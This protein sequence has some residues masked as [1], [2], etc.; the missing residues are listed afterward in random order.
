MR[1]SIPAAPS[2]F[3][4]RGR[5]HAVTDAGSSAAAAS[6]WSFEVDDGVSA[7]RVRHRAVRPRRAGRRGCLAADLLLLAPAGRLIGQAPAPRRRSTKARRRVRTSS[8]SKQATSRR[9]SSRSAAS[10]SAS[11]PRA[12]SALMWARPSAGCAASS[13]ARVVAASPSASGGDDPRH[14][15]DP[16]GLLGVDP[17]TG[18]QQVPGPALPDDAWQQVAHPARGAQAD[19][20]I[21]E[22]EDRVGRG[23]ADVARERELEAAG[24][25]VA[26]YGGDRRDRQC[27]HPPRES[28]RR[29]MKPANSSTD[30]ASMPVRSAPAE[31]ARPLP[32]RTRH[33][34]S[35]DAATVATASRSAP[36]SA[37]S[38]ALSTCGRSSRSV[39]TAPSRSTRRDVVVVTSVAPGRPDDP[40]GLRLGPWQ[41]CRAATSS[42]SGVNTRRSWMRVAIDVA[43]RVAASPSRFASARSS[44]TSGGRPWGGA[45][46]STTW[47]SPVSRAGSRRSPCQRRADTR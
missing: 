9:S 40:A 15:P 5:A 22:T 43:S 4:L 38:S 41:A 21:G 10:K 17:L 37:P 1:M 20:R 18:Q 42:I 6:S 35:G 16:F 44:R 25:G 27:A 32:A 8:V 31:N 11:V 2:E 3:L 19:R 47:N 13:R 28:W 46:R 34:A 29:P 45:S 12:S 24:Q 26:V 14:E 30:I 33:R 39:T 36:T 7:V 23:D